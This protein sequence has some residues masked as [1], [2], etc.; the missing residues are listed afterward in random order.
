[1]D[2]IW[3][4]VYLHEG[5]VGSS[6]V[7]CLDEVS[8]RK[9]FRGAHAGDGESSV[10]LWEVPVTAGKFTYNQG[11]CLDSK[12]GHWPDEEPWEE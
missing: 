6:M 4:V 11:Q 3:L 10:H 1:M 5:D 2:R 7:A 8:G 9:A 12:Y